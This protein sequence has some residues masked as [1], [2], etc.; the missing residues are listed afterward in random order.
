MYQCPSHVLIHFSCLQPSYWSPSQNSSFFVLTSCKLE[1]LWSDL[2][3]NNQSTIY[4]SYRGNYFLP[5]VSWCRSDIL[6]SSAPHQQLLRHSVSL[7]LLA[8]TCI[9]S[10]PLPFSLPLLF[11]I[12]N[13]PNRWFA[14]A[15]EVL[16]IFLYHTFPIFLHFPSSIVQ[17]LSPSWI[18]V[19]CSVL[20]IH[21]IY[22]NL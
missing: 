13:F 15:K 10:H 20:A 12:A 9:W 19:L 3:C 5:Y 2:S 11:Q 8:P 18:C 17:Y 6:S 16:Q 21:L 4:T 7:L 22:K 1:L 14:M